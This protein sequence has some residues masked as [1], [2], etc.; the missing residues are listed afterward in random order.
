M[1]DPPPH[2]QDQTISRRGFVQAA[3]VAAA[4]PLVMTRAALAENVKALGFEVPGNGFIRIVLKI[5][6][7]AE[8]TG[9]R[10]TVWA[11]EDFSVT[12]GKRAVLTYGPF[13]KRQVGSSKSIKTRG[14]KY[15]LEFTG[16]NM[17]YRIQAQY[18][19]ENGPKYL[20]MGESSGKF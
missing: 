20:N 11:T 18:R 12:K 13:E 16:A 19:P 14:G 5:E 1:I 4:S 3:C 6:P 8:Q 9:F 10:A 7:T 15:S 2:N 17:Q